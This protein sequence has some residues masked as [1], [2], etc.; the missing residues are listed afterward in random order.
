MN[1]L[2]SVSVTATA[3]GR[4]EAAALSAADATGAAL[5]AGPV[6]RWVVG[7][8][9]AEVPAQ[10]AMNAL[11]PA[12][13]VPARNPRRLT[14]VRD[15]RASICSRSRSRSVIAL[16]PPP[17]APR[18]DPLLSSHEDEIRSLVPADRDRIARSEPLA[19]A[20]PKLVLAAGDELAGAI[21]LD[22]VLRLLPQVGALPDTSGN[23][24]PAGGLGIAARRRGLH[25][26]VLRPDGDGHPVAGVRTGVRVGHPANQLEAAVG[27]D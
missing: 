15:I 1:S 20:V 6:D 27:R 21:G 18:A 4:T 16:P 19:R 24:G 11:R 25:P 13:P 9:V 23:A 17:R 3:D 8:F 14:L 2:P 5:G 10:A 12:R 22:A 7:L 26:E